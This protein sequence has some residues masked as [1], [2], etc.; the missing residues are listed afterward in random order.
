M[1]V[2]VAGEHSSSFAVIECKLYSVLLINISINKVAKP[3]AI[4][5]NELMSLSVLTLT[6]MLVNLFRYNHIDK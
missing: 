5:Q 2:N 4:Y 1:L 3:A 6:L